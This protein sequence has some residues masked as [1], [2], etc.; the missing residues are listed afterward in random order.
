MDAGPDTLN[1]NIETVGRVFRRVR[2]KGDY[3]QSLELLRRVKELSPGA[4]TKSGMMVGLGETWDELVDT[5]RDLRAANCDLLTIGQYLR[6]SQ[7]HAPV[8]KWYTPE[9]FDELRMEGE[10]L[11]FHHVASGPLVRS[12]Y[13]ADEQHETAT[14]GRLTLNPA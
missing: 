10:A 2:P 4:V 11:G 13:H 12:S 7:K 1:H 14:S 3:D 9:E 6:P 5:M 8:T